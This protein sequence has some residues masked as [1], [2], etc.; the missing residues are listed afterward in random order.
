MHKEPDRFDTFLSFGFRPFFLFAG[1]YAIAA[2][3]AWL[4]W[5]GLH[6]AGAAVTAPSFAV[7]PHYWH[8]HE[9]IFGYGGAVLAGFLLTAVVNWTGTRPVTGRPLL[10]LIMVW[11]AGRIAVWLSA[12]VPAA[13]VAVVDLAFL[14]L[15]GLFVA[16]ALLAKPAARNLIFPG[17]LAVL[18][19]ANLMIHLEWTG[20]IDDGARLGLLAA[21][22][23]L[24]FTVSIVGGRIVPAFTRN[25]LVK[26]HEAIPPPRTITLVDAIALASTALLIPAAAFALSDA[27]TGALA[28]VA[29]VAHAVRLSFWRFHATLNDP[30]LWSLHLAYFWLPVG[31]AM[32][33]A[34][35]LG[36]GMSESTALHALSIG[37]VG[38]MTLAVMSR[39]ALG[40]TGR[41][42]A[43][44]WPTAC[45]YGLI[46]A[47]ALVR[48]GGPVLF[49]ALYMQ[50]VLAA[51]FLWAA[52]FA[53]F[54]LVYWPVLTGPPMRGT[55]PAAPGQ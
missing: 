33:A 25:A 47:A 55:A 43:A 12:L 27:L 42:L 21:L 20:L 31:F 19:A 52:G 38:G 11:L 35:H 2:I 8:A 40:H 30:L 1:L 23:T 15:L 13:V 37:A 24:C 28:L 53:L 18:S 54:A 10:L 5:L 32:L 6:G 29:A 7:T 9:M 45:A 36:A 41:P 44:A 14:P 50:A 16:R 17:L 3:A 51:G 39:A 26:R 34:A 4:T 48:A 49:P 46:A 22:L